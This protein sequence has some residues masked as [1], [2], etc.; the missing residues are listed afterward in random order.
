MQTHF[1]CSIWMCISFQQQ[2]SYPNLPILGCHMER[3][4]SFLRR[5]TGHQNHGESQPSS[6][7]KGPRAKRYPTLMGMETPN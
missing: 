4:K 6:L 5:N 1:S 7:E 2:L 3:G